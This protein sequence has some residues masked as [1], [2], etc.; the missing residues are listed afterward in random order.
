MVC[1]VVVCGLRGKTVVVLFLLEGRFGVGLSLVSWGVRND[2]GIWC[3]SVTGI[4]W[5]KAYLFV[6]I[7]LVAATY[8]HLPDSQSML[9][10]ELLHTE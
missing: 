4:A 7:V 6:D 2:R 10:L 8:K 5:R 1:V 3:L 9:F